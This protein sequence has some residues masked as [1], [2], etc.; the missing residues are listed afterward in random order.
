MKH[1]I[2]DNMS[3]LFREETA[4]YNNFPTRNLNDKVDVEEDI[5]IENNFPL[6][7]NNEKLTGKEIN[8]IQTRLMQ[9]SG[10]PRSSAEDYSAWRKEYAKNVQEIL[11]DESLKVQ[12]KNSGEEKTLIQLIKEG[13]Y[14]TAS[15]FIID[16]YY[17]RF[18]EQIEYNKRTLQ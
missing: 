6:S 7:S 15:W 3:D 11:S 4:K 2:S 8:E 5:D 12:D 14:T 10:V 16:E 18:G 13:D 1:N 17:K 9:M